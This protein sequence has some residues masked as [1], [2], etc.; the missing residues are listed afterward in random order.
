[1]TMVEPFLNHTH[2][3]WFSFQKELRLRSSKINLMIIL[4]EKVNMKSKNR[5]LKIE[6]AFLKLIM[7]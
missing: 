5:F 3:V 7:M 2:S 6:I 1:M 4:K